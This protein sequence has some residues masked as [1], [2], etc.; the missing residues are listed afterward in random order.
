LICINAAG[1]AAR[2]RLE[3]TARYDLQCLHCAGAMHPRSRSD[4]DYAFFLRMLGQLRPLGVREI[5]LSYLGE[6]FLCRWLP[7]A[8]RH[9]KEE[10][11]FE[12]RVAARAQ[13]EVLVARKLDAHA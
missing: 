6:P 3:L 11:G 9:A 10:M 8:I 13:P 5:G 4:M 7:E 1:H 12:S 2:V